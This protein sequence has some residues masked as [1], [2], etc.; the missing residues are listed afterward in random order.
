HRTARMEALV[1][2][3]KSLFQNSI[4]AAE[5]VRR[6]EARIKATKDALTEIS[7]R[8][9]YDATLF[10]RLGHTF[11]QR[12]GAWEAALVFERLLKEYPQAEERELAFAELV[13]AYADAGRVD[14][15]RTAMD[16]F[17]RALPESKLLP[18]A[19]YVAAQAAFDENR[20]DLQL[21]FL[22]VGIQQF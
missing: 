20:E 17:M 21:E 3:Q 9:D 11:L 4:F 1:A 16:E 12:G 18:Q 19:L 5:N 6:V 10:Y 8:E 7:K 2:R 13:R 22:E 14:R 15:M